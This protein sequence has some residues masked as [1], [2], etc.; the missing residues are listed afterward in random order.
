MPAASFR[1]N[2]P[3][4]DW[5][6]AKAHLCA[7]IIIR[8]DTTQC[9]VVPRALRRRPY[10]KKAAA[11]KAA[12]TGNCR[13]IATRR[14]NWIH[15]ARHRGRQEETERIRRRAGICRENPLG[16]GERR[17]ARSISPLM[18]DVASISNQTN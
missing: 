2:R 5:R 4:P 3:V 9:A 1:Q 13:K 6:M 11:R 10:R 16:C 15:I 7:L 8:A 17:L 18:D 14:S 12:L